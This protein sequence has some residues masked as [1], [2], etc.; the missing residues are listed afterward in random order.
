MILDKKDLMAIAAI[1]IVGS[2]VGVALF[3]WAKTKWTKV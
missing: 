3:S 1:V 2:G